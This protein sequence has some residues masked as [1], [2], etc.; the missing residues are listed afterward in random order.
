VAYQRFW[1]NRLRSNFALG[2]AGAENFAGQ[3]GDSFSNSHFLLG[4]LMYRFNSCL[5][6]GIEYNHDERQNL[7]GS[8]SDNH[9]VMIGFQLF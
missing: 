7:A 2:Y 3:P 4:N 1:N 6:A 9:R 8:D 5:T